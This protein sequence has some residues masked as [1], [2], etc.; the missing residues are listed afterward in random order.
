M[1][2]GNTLAYNDT[3]KITAIKSFIVMAP[4]VFLFLNRAG[5]IPLEWSLKGTTE[6][7]TLPKTNKSKSLA[8][9]NTL[10]YFNSALIS[11]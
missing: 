5:Y 4:G 11:K 6:E 3:A 7:A 9:K 8:V 1:E 10:A 2:A